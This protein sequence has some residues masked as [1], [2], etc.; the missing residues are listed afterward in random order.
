MWTRAR[1]Q[2]APR[3]MASRR[4]TG[5]WR[6]LVDD[7]ADPR[8]LDHHAQHRCTR[9]WRWRPSPPAS[10]FIARSRCR[11]RSRL[12]RD[13]GGGREGGRR[14]AGW[15]Q[16][17][18]E[19]A[20]EA[21]AR[22]GR[23]QASWARSPAFAASMPKTTCMIP[24]APTSGASI[25]C[26]GPGRDRRPRLAHHRHGAFPAGSHRR[27]ERR[28]AHRREIAPGGAGCRRTREGRQVDD[29]ARMLRQFRAGLR[30]H[31]R[32]QLDGHGPQDA[33]GLRSLRARRAGWSSRR[34]ASTSSISTGPAATPRE[35]RLH[36]DRDRPAASALW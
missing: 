34:S 26:G 1:R 3:N 8:R 35:L 11:R 30:R 15:L 22:H 4:S 14:D 13:G 29:V 6:A 21:G 17:H 32:G 2:A 19:P 23:R 20:A 9:R 5:D 27:G 36:P 10:M 24:R 16:L 25:P 7:P 18:Q 28:C 12:A 33:A 31:H